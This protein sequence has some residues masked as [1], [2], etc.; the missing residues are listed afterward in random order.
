MG[1]VGP[2]EINSNIKRY[3]CALFRMAVVGQ[4]PTGKLDLHLKTATEACENLIETLR[5]GIVADEAHKAV[6]DVFHKNGIPEKLGHR[7]AYGLGVSY[8]PDTGEGHFAMIREGD[9]HILEPG[10]VFHLVPGIVEFGEW[11]CGNTETVHITEN[12]C[13]VIT[14][15][16]RDIYIS[17][18]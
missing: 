6:R 13:E 12:G 8:P 14:N 18:Q 16:P 4:K 1:D 17:D 5:G 9:Q 11:T 10:M 3:S 15:Y 7:V 2:Y